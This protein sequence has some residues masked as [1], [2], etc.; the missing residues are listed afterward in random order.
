[1]HNLILFEVVSFCIRHT[2]SEI[3]AIAIGH[4]DAEVV[5]PVCKERVLVC[6]NVWMLQS[7]HEH[8]FVAASVAAGRERESERG[9]GMGWDGVGETVSEEGEKCEGWEA[10][11]ERLRPSQQRRNAVGSRR[12]VVYANGA[13]AFVCVDVG[14]QIPRVNFERDARDGWMDGSACCECGVCG[15]PSP[16]LGRNALQLDDLHD[17]LPML[18]HVPD[19]VDLAKATFADGTDD[20]EVLHGGMGS[21]LLVVKTSFPPLAN[22]NGYAEEKENRI[23][24]LKES[25][26]VRGHR[27]QI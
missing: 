10:V 7:L 17:I 23:K 16:F 24:A 11:L 5:T 15:T 13:C 25:L 1:M 12:P 21:W 9:M 6:D 14:G 26:R 8:D 22:E 20:L 2:L 18:T 4:D 27:C 3:T 19:Q